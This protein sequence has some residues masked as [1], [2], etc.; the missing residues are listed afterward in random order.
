MSGSDYT[1]TDQ[2][3]LLSCRPHTVLRWKTTPYL[4]VMQLM[5]ARLIAVLFLE[6]AT[7]LVLDLSLGVLG[8][9]TGWVLILVTLALVSGVENAFCRICCWCTLRKMEFWCVERC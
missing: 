5:E 9:P 8:K 4:G 7:E 3:L 2:N 1:M 6:V